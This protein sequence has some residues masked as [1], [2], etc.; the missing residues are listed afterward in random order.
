M[1]AEAGAEGKWAVLY[2]S[3]MLTFLM[4]EEKVVYFPCISGSL[5]AFQLSFLGAQK[6]SKRVLCA[7]GFLGSQ[8]GRLSSHYTVLDLVCPIT[9]MVP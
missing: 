7:W 5:A 6:V 2:W 9:T 1:L 3:G 4:L 8:S